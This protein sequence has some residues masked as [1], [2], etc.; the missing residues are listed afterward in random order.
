MSNC[1][2]PSRLLPQTSS[3]K[4][5]SLPHSQNL[6]LALTISPISMAK[7]ASPAQTPP[8]SFPTMDSSA[9]PAFNPRFLMP[10]S[11]AAPPPKKCRQILRLLTIWSWMEGHW[12][13]GRPTTSTTRQRIRRSQIVH[14][15]NPSSTASPAS[16]VQLILPTSICSTASVR[17]VPKR[18]LTTAQWGSV[19][20]LLET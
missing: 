4:W 11:S 8:P 7:P 6:S 16:P 12:T 2:H 19:S 3:K 10:I 14:P 20:A 18:Q 17:P 13:S 15:R 5:P 1:G 9:P